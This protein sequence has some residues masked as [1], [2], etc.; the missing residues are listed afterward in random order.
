VNIWKENVMEYLESRSLSYTI[1][2]EF[3][4]DLREKFKKGD[5]EMIKVAEL[6]NV[7]QESRMMEKFVQEFRRVARGSGYKGRPL[8][9]EFK[10]GMNRIIKQKLM[11]SEHPPK[12]I[13]Q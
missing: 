2:G 13:K 3:L 12:N 8:V 1:V 11:E 10:R 9:E 5:N 6:K 4:S 7:K